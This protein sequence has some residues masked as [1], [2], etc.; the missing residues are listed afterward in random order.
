MTGREPHILRYTRWLRETHGLAFDATTSEGYERFW[1]WSCDDLPAF[2]QS[3]WDYYGVVSPTPHAAV[4]ADASMPG[5]RWF[6][7]ARVNYAGHVLAH[8][9]PHGVDVVGADHRHRPLA[10]SVD[11]KFGQPGRVDAQDDL[12]RQAGEARF[13]IDRADVAPRVAPQQLA[14]VGRGDVELAA[15]DQAQQQVERTLEVGQPDVKTGLR[16]RVGD[17]RRAHDAGGPLSGRALRASTSMA[18]S[19]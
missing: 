14:Q 15:A 5:A 6:A 3:I 11:R 4:L 16:C 2:W 8:A 7:G 10:H 1:R 13:E 18:S 9:D 19:R 17:G 12:G